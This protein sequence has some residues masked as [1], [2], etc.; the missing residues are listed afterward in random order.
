VIR[1]NRIHKQTNRIIALLIVALLITACGEAQGGFVLQ[2]TLAG[3]YSIDPLFREFYDHLGGA[4]VLGPAIT[5]S[6]DV[7]SR[8][9]Q[10][11]QAG[12]MEYDPN[13]PGS[14]RFLLSPLGLEMNI[15]EPF[16]APPTN[17]NELYV[18]GHIIFRG[19]VNLYRALGGARFAGKPLTEV[20]FNPDKKRYE[21]Y[22]ENLGFF[23]LESDP[24]DAVRLL[25]YGSWKCAGQCESL[26]PVANEIT[27]PSLNPNAVTDLFTSIVSRLGPGL[28]GFPLSAP[29]L[30]DDGMYEQI[31]EYVVLVVDAQNPSRIALRPLPEKIG[32]LVEQPVPANGVEGMVFWPT[33]GDQGH[34]VP[35]A[36]IDFI[37][38][39]G[40]TEVSGIP[41]SELFLASDQIFRQCFTHYC[42]DY[43]MQ[44]TTPDALRIRPAA[45]GYTYKELYFQTQDTSFAET[46]DLHEISLQVWEKHPFV[47]ST[48]SQEIG[49]SLFEGTQPLRNV[50]PVLTLTMPDGT[51][52]SVY[53]PP[54]GLDG[55]TIK[56]LDPIN[57]PNGT[58]IP[59]QVCISSL[60]GERFCVK[61]SF[62]I[63]YNE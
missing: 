7:E 28:T 2:P 13:A 9:F 34:N 1:V 53:F 48:Q 43:Y 35:Q 38:L 16:V 61:D 41:I 56:Q 3:A 62:V 63:W 8:R 30:A 55:Q 12:C 46:Q 21:Q 10:Y 42:L 39:H 54:T 15:Q 32:I 27:L 24:P 51:E 50:E 14:E 57:A 49:A 20:H 5:P 23:L 59:Y 19:F 26:P 36:F 4:A 22:F 18:D 6:F 17:E 44:S 40:G 11:V 29:Y 58:L 25:A 45:F 33:S 31:F 37:I 60:T 52:Q 47:S